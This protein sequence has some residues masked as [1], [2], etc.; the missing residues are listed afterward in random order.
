MIGV[1]S[2]K[3]PGEHDTAAVEHAVRRLAVGHPVVNNRDFRVWR[4]YAVRA[5][6]TLMFLDPDGKVIGF[7]EGEFE[8]EAL[9]GVIGDMIA[10]FDAEAADR[11]PAAVVHGPRRE[12]AGSAPFLP[13]QGAG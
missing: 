3:F 13:R 8:A 1:H 9:D 2:P 6:P 11:P 5:W 4:A 10:A 7:H 12:R